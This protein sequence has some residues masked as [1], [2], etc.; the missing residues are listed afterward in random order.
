MAYLPNLQYY[1]IKKKKKP[2]KQKKKRKF[3]GFI[4]YIAHRST[5]RNSFVAL[6][7]IQSFGTRF[8]YIFWTVLIL[9]MV[10]Y[11]LTNQRLG[12]ADETLIPYLITR[13]VICITKK[14]AL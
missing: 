9:I 3:R 12:L 6:Y 10:D 1:K 2:N 7:I 11:L 13:V 8:I 4:F 14:I 5:F